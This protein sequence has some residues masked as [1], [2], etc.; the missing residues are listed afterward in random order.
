M[1]VHR[2]G[3]VVACTILV[4]TMIQIAYKDHTQFISGSILQ[5]RVEGEKYITR[6]RTKG[7][8]KEYPIVLEVAINQMDHTIQDVQVIEHSETP[9]YGGYITQNWFLDKFQSKEVA[10]PLE[11]VSIIEKESNEV[12]AITG[13]TVSSQA[14]VK[15]VNQALEQYKSTRR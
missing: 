13:A 11:C 6:V 8:H 10:I 2:V 5:V 9:D 15:G 3:Q 14:V 12:V 7:F 1:K 4:A